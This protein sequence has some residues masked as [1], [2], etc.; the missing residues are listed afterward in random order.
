MPAATFRCCQR[1]VSKYLAEGANIMS[2][3]KT[4]KAE[5]ATRLD[6]EFKS[7][8]TPILLVAAG[9]LLLVSNLFHWHLINLLWPGF[10]IVPGLL[11]M[12]PAHNSTE[13]QVSR[14]SFLAIPGALLATIGFLLLAMNMTGRFD[15]WAYSWSLLPASAVAGLMYAK[16]FSR[17]SSINE[18][19]RKFI[20]LSVITFVG[21][22]TLFEIII[23][24]NFNPL[25]PLALIGYG[26]YLLVKDRREDA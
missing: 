26:I 24:E 19:G 3:E 4:F 10:V 17:G 7:A 22:A 12:L 6:F 11:L 21:L 23:F 1:T 18:S 5:E 25:L 14:L 9:F 13:D 16:R 2:D 20:R 8:W 15:A